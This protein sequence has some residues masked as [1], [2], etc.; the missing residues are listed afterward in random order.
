MTEELINKLDREGNK[1]LRDTLLGVGME[2]RE[3]ISPHEE[4]QED[5][6]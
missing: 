4:M 6:L 2:V 1:A 5:R 3:I